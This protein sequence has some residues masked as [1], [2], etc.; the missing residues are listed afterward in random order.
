MM[1]VSGPEEVDAPR[2]CVRP[3][4]AKDTC[5]TALR[6]SLLSAL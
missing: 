5:V 2:S 1:T 3:S 4:A 6:D